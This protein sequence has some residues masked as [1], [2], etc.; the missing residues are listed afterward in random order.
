LGKKEDRVELAGNWYDDNYQEDEDTHYETYAHPHVLPPHLLAYTISAS[1]KVLSG[2]GKIVSLFLKVIN[3][4]SSFCD[5]GDILSHGRCSFL[6]VLHR[7]RGSF[8]Y[9]V[10]LNGLTILIASIFFGC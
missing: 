4:C 6:Y 2:K 5:F 9:C 1:S 7:L 3:A 10:A 8:S